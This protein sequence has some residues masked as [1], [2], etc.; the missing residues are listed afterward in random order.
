MPRTLCA[1]HLRGPR[2]KR[3]ATQGRRA[4][5]TCA[6]WV[7]DAGTRNF[8]ETKG[9]HHDS[10]R[11]DRTLDDLVRLRVHDFPDRRQLRHLAV[12]HCRQARQR[13]VGRLELRDLAGRQSALEP[14]DIH[15]IRFDV[16]A[17]LWVR[18]DVRA[19]QPT[20]IRVLVRP[21]LRLPAPL[22]SHAGCTALGQPA[23]AV[24]AAPARAAAAPFP[25]T[26]CTPFPRARR[27]A[28]FRR[29]LGG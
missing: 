8:R 7:N 27:W 19:G 26:A 6:V 1:R 14:G 18:I 5:A 3:R 2:P 25:P 20:G 9:N 13:G 28:S 23:P 15:A 29:P 11:I 16:R 22:C 12:R 21:R 17:N 4:A 10:R 24:P